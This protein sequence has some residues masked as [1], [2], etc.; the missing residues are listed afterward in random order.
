MKKRL[1]AASMDELMDLITW[2]GDHVGED[3]WPADMDAV[4]W[5]CTLEPG[6]HEIPD[7]YVEAIEMGIEDWCEVLKHY[8][9][10]FETCVVEVAE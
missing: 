10:T 5:L 7:E 8:L 6:E 1:I 2:I 9:D 3:D 4:H